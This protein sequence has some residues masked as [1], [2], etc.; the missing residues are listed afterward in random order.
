MPELFRH[1]ERGTGCGTGEHLNHRHLRPGTDRAVVERL[2]GDRVTRQGHTDLVI[3][4]RKF[5]G[6]AQRRKS[7]AVLF[8]GTL[9]LGFDLPVIEEL[10]PMPTHQPEY[11]KGRPHGGFLMN[12][13]LD[14]ATLTA[15]LQE[16]WGATTAYGN[17]P[18]DAIRTLAESRDLNH[19]WTYRF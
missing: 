8:H 13:G 11:R 7:K 9:L 6:N 15:A 16:E 4:G 3:N 5:S 10:L 19:D 14:A 18:L 17:L 2:T 1:F 12:L